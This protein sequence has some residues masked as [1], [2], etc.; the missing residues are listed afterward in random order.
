MSQ[1][2]HS[3]QMSKSFFNNSPTKTQSLLQDKSKI[4]YYLKDNMTLTD[5]SGLDIKGRG[6]QELDDVS[7][8]HRDLE[9][10]LLDNNRIEDLQGIQQFQN[11]K[12][13]SLINNQIG[14][15]LNVYHLRGLSQIENLDLRG[16][17]I[18]T[19][20]AYRHTVLLFLKN[21]KMLD[22]KPVK[23]S[24]R[25]KIPA[26]LSS[27]YSLLDRLLR[28]YVEILRLQS[29]AQR[30]DILKELLSLEKSYLLTYVHFDL[31]KLR[32]LYNYQDSINEKIRNGF[33]AD[34]LSDIRLIELEFLH[35]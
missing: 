30:L 5:A 35:K 10:L 23:A 31:D 22:G 20:P 24:E 28:N 16:N 14:D 26:E 25:L 4:S 13:L 7:E 17:P 8:H 1:T 11:I 19:R 18:I 27:Q 29:V 2:G 9:T 12:H 15:I 21:L 6:I 33:R 3:F 32:R 34:L